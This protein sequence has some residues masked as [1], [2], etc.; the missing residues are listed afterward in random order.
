MSRAYAQWS[1]GRAQLGMGGPEEPL[2]G[3]DE[4][5]STTS[6]MSMPAAKADSLMGP[7]TEPIGVIAQGK[8]AMNSAVAAGT[9]DMAATDAALE[10]DGMTAEQMQTGSARGAKAN[11]S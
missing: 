11:G 1:A 2:T 4:M 6:D 10:N 7:T 9:G 3:K 5:A 8:T